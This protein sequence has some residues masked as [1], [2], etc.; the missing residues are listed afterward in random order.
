MGKRWSFGLKI[1]RNEWIF[2]YGPPGSGKSSVGRLLAEALALPFVD[3]DL[4]IE[5]A[6]GRS[7]SEVF[8]VQ[9]EMAFRRQEKET[10]QRLLAA[11]PAV[12][13][14]GGGALLDAGSRAL[15]VS[16]GPVVCLSV[17]LAGLRERLQT[18]APNRP[19]LAGDLAGRLANLL[20]SRSEHYASFPLQVKN[21]GISMEKAAWQA[22]VR[23]GRF[24][25]RG[26]GAGYDVRVLPGE[27]DRLG[28][29]LAGRDLGGPVALVSD[30]HVAPLYAQR[31]IRSLASASL[32]ARLVTIPAGEQHKTIATVQALWDGFLKAGLERSST[33]L[34]LGGG[35]T[36]DLAGFA[37]ATF[38]RGV[39]W[40]AVPTSLLAMVDASLGGKTGADLPQGKN[41]VGAFYPPRYILADPQVLSSLPEREARGGM[42]EVV[43]AA[44]IADPELFE[45]CSQGW[46]AV[47]NCWA[48]I[49]PRAMA[50]KV[51]FIQID[52]YEHG[53]RAALN[54]G[55]TIGHA[56]ERVSNYQISHGEA[57]AIGMVVEAR[58]AE[59]AGLAQSGLADRI[60]SVLA[61]LGLPVKIP[62]GLPWDEIVTAMQVDKKRQAGSLRF[63]L[64]AA[65][66][67]VRTGV[68]IRPDE[69]R[70]L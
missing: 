69:L 33:V 6:S 50:V 51:R 10:L 62:A 2:V 46:E 70:S 20:A 23:L 68:T 67:D 41:L 58:L 65:I 15:V 26:M 59:R 40:A 63:A 22:Q 60:E 18:T 28:Q 3:V 16:R 4:E 32:D 52:P 64:P 61:G 43:K 44:I 53:P 24:Y 49:V 19:L 45:T 48:E 30:E 37:A 7:I 35:V 14:L 5:K 9:G 17:S 39:A 27:L 31:V 55:H 42:A 8:S 29:A 11:Q 66:G 13:A 25:V 54:L 56:L 34:A 57:V 36:G 1:M 21:E 47:K 12:L 38:L